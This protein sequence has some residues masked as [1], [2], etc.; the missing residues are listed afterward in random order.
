MS[1]MQFISI[2]KTNAKNV[3]SD[4]QPW[5]YLIVSTLPTNSIWKI[6]LIE[7]LLEY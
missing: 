6:V 3:I 1:Y 7:A 4:D 5:N 2:K